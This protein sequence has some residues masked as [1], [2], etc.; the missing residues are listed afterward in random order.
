MAKKNDLQNQ[1]L[2]P[3]MFVPVNADKVLSDVKFDTKPVGYLMDAWRRFK[4][5]KA[6]VVAAC[7]IL[8][9][10]LFAIIAPIVSPY[11]MSEVDGYYK[12]TRPKIAGMNNSG[13]G[14]WDGTYVKDQSTLDYIYFNG[15]A[16]GALDTDFD[17]K[18]DWNEVLASEFNPIKKELDDY[19]YTTQV[20]GVDIT[21]HRYELRVDSYYEVGFRSVEGITPEE[22]QRI[23]DWEQETGLKVIYPV[24]NFNDADAFDSSNI[25]TDSQDNYWYRN[26]RGTNGGTVPIDINGNELTLEQVMNGELVP[27][28]AVRYDETPDGEYIVDPLKGYVLAA[29]LSPEEFAAL[30]NK[31]YSTFIE[32]RLNGIYAYYNGSYVL[33]SSLTPEQLVG[34]TKRYR[35]NG[36]EAEDGAYVFDGNDYALVSSLSEAELARAYARYSAVYTEDSKKGSYFLVDG[37]YKQGTELGWTIPQ[38]EA[39]VN[40]GGK[41]YKQSFVLDYNGNYVLDGK[42]Y[43]LESSMSADALASMVVRY[44]I[45]WRRD[46]QG[47]HT[48][49]EGE[50]VLYD[51]LTPEQQDSLLTR[52]HRVDNATYIRTGAGGKNY[53]IRVLYYNYYRYLNDKE[54]VHVF[55]ADSQGYDILVRLAMGARLS[56]VLAV[57]VAAINLIFGSLYGAISGYYGG[58]VDMVMERITDVLAGIPTIVLMTLVRIHLIEGSVPVM[59]GD[60]LLFN[61]HLTDMGGIIFAMCATGW[62]GTA[63]SVRMQFYRFKRQEYILAAR[64][65]GA[66]DGRLMFRHIFPNAL[67]TLITGSVLVIPGVI[68]SET[69]LAYLGVIS[70]TGPNITSLGAMLSN[71]QSAGISKFPHIIFFPALILS[72]LMISFNLF[73]NGLRDAFNPSLRGSEE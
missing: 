5:N 3:D 13:S 36:V 46:T 50:Y 33:A 4:R 19:D 54:P 63:Y 71:G 37:E 61:L 47:K 48:L 35:Q 7:I 41:K 51:S 14:F 56:L 21:S 53:R 27:N 69:S 66:R 24:I 40:G 17:G 15:I 42:N 32:D 49:F 72:L 70:F 11:E 34:N 25:N 12:H 2:T 1:H 31:R 22:Y 67:G 57:C 60:T 55:G 68:F 45:D 23:L 64:T 18:H 73:G 39:Y 59:I 10:A 58:K 29:S 38:I 52:Y 43:K 26:K 28:Y 20:N 16:M 9:I 65:L 30:T 6:S 8:I 62:I 44:N